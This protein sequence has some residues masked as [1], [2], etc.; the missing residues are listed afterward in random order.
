MMPDKLDECLG[1]IDHH[2]LSN[3]P[4]SDGTVLQRVQYSYR[5]RGWEI[6]QPPVTFIIPIFMKNKGSS[7]RNQDRHLRYRGETSNDV[8]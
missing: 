1:G 3:C 4:S 7:G 2:I 5:I 6:L 8:T